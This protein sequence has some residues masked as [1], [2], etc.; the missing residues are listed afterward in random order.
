M[1]GP[2]KLMHDG[3]MRSGEVF[4]VPVLHKN[5]TFL[6]G[7][8]VSGHFFKA[9]DDEMSQ[10]EVSLLTLRGLL[11]FKLSTWSYQLCLQVHSHNAQVHNLDGHNGRRKALSRQIVRLTLARR[12]MSSMFQ[13]LARGWCLM[14][15]TR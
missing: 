13:P 12:F 9:N 6:L 2:M 1:Q 14:W 15:I 4:T 5:F 8:H 11:P 7:P 3:Y 10:K